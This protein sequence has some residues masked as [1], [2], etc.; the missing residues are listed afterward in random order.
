MKAKEKNNK[1]KVSEFIR[2][3]RGEMTKREENAFQ[4]EL[5]KDP[6]AEEADEGFSLITSE[7][8][9]SDIRTLQNRLKGRVRKR[10]NVIIYRIAAS[11]AVLMII[12]AIFVITRRHEP[13][14]TLSENIVQEKMSPVTSEE[15]TPEQV[16]EMITAD[17]KEEVPVSREK[18]KEKQSVS[19]VSKKETEEEVTGLMI[20][21]TAQDTTINTKVVDSQPQSE[22]ARVTAD[23]AEALTAVPE[24]NME[25]AR[26][27]GAPAN[28]RAVSP[29][30]FI[31]PQPVVGKDSFDIYI[32]KS[33]KNPYPETTEQQVVILNF[34]VGIDS[35]VSNITVV[36]TPGEAYSGEAIRLIKEGPVWKPAQ[37]N[38][39]PVA[40]EVTLRVV[41][42]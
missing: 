29:G 22:P 41:F 37:D 20:A 21:E 36:D 26:A 19:T 4:R 1:T 33:I 10:S 11:V 6:F 39:N 27:V 30:E 24:R 18:E 40:D 15:S 3:V 5:Q 23:M 14:L 16:P 17:K 8:A 13:A 2:Y 35:T 9:E 42:K 34:T 7:E 12:S 31:P 25:M 38:G 32:E 28:A